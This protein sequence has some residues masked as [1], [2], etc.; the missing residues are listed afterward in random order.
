[1]ST[2]LRKHEL[3]DGGVVVEIGT[4]AGRQLACDHVEELLAKAGIQVVILG[5]SRVFAF[6]VPETDAVRAAELL[7]SDLERGR[8]SITVYEA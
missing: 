6:G 1:M 3:I 7:R 2:A 8:H 5:G 4:C